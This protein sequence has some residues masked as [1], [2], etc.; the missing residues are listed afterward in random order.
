MGVGVEA[1][2]G[3]EGRKSHPVTLRVFKMIVCPILRHSC[4]QHMFTE[5]LPGGRNCDVAYKY[6]QD[7]VLHLREFM[8]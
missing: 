8:V 4:L 6:L 7:R 3:E 1:E 5:D 2:E